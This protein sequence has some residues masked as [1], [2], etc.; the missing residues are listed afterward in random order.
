[1][2]KRTSKSRAAGSALSTS[3]L[4]YA[5][6]GAALGLLAGAGMLVA[7]AV[8]GLQA[9]SA[10]QRGVTRAQLIAGGLAAGSAAAAVGSYKL[11]FR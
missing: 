1:M 2:A 5:V 3:Q 11:L 7:G 8:W 9:V 6:G 10:G 4:P